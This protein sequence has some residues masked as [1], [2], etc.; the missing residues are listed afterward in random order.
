MSLAPKDFPLW[1]S[2]PLFIFTVHTVASLLEVISSASTL[3]ILALLSRVTSA[4]YNAK[5]RG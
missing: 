4:L 1:V 2:T 3:T 5:M